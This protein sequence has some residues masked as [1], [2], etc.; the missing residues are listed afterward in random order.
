MFIETP[1]SPTYLSP[2]GATCVW[3]TFQNGFFRK[4]TI[5][6]KRHLDRFL[7]IGSGFFKRFPLRVSTGQFFNKS[8]VPLWNFFVNCG[9][10][11]IRNFLDL[12]GFK[13]TCLV[14]LLYT[15]RSAGARGLDLS[16]SIDISLRWS[17]DLRFVN[18]G[19]LH[20]RNFLDLL[21]FKATCLVALLYTLRS[22]GARG[23]DVSDFY[24]HIAPLERGS[25]LRR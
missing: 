22:A 25:P 18:C 19:E 21:G 11:R 1:P 17:E 15:L 16:D 20:I 14:A 9:E 4:N 5:C 13:A 12:L 3:R 10:L 8:D 23:L 6:F 7:E 24:R 2:R